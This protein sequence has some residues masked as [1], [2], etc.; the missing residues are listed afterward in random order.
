MSDETPETLNQKINQ[1]IVDHFGLWWTDEN[2]SA[3]LRDAGPEGLAKI[4]EIS[5]FANQPD[6][7]IYASSTDSAYNEVQKVLGQEYPFLSGRAILRIASSAAYG[8]K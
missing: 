8:W 4:E 3:I 1:A 7:W 5:S 2:R 6:L